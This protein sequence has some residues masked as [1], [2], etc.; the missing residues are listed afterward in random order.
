[1]EYTRSNPRP[2]SATREHRTHA[3]HEEPQRGSLPPGYGKSSSGKAAPRACPGLPVLSRCLSCPAACPVPLPG[4]ASALGAAS[5]DPLQQPVELQLHR[6]PM[7]C[8][9]VGERDRGHV[10]LFPWVS[11]FYS[12]SLYLF[13]QGFVSILTL[14]ST[15]KFEIYSVAINKDTWTYTVIQKG[16]TR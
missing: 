2:V 14:S 3:R 12:Y 9:P 5:R 11:L 7:D 13:C 10:Q 16:C 1:M 6:E 4:S 8:R 15:S